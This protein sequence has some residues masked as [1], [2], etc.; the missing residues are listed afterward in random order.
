[1]WSIRMAPEREP[2]GRWDSLRLPFAPFDHG[3]A[4]ENVWRLF[5]VEW[6]QGQM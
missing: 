6:R 4:R 2:G 5:L 1:M 3:L